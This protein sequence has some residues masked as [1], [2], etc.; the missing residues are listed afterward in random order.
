[1]AETFHQLRTGP[2]FFCRRHFD[3]VFLACDKDGRSFLCWSF[4][5][6]LCLFF[7]KLRRCGRVTLAVLDNDGHCRGDFSRQSIVF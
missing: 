7:V 4:L 2:L 6:K 1:M 5:W 3:E